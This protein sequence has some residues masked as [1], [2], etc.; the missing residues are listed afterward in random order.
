[1]TSSKE[2]SDMKESKLIKNAQ[3]G[4]KNAFCE[5][6]EL[7]K[8]R[9]FRYAYYKLSNEADAEDA[10]MDCVL[11]AWQDIT[12][13]KK[14]EAFPAWIF[15]ILRLSCTKY[16]DAQA[17]S[18]ANQ[19]LDDMQND[20]SLS[21]CYSDLSLELRQA[22]DKLQA[23]EKEVVLLCL[24]AGFTSTQCSKIVGLKPSSV[25]SKLSRSLA[26]MRNYLE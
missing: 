7:Y 17:K 11:C 2:V 26:K 3:K 25:R 20:T 24:V 4:D 9:L 12:K 1:M 6:Y 10:V 8:N 15:K 19:T 22:L 5:L 14:A 18:R 16:I 13:L 21:Y 23:D